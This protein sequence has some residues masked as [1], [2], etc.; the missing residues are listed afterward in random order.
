MFLD[1]K[2]SS[3]KIHKNPRNFFLVLDKLRKKDEDGKGFD[4]KFLFPEHLAPAQVLK[5]SQGHGRERER[6][7]L[8]VYY[9]SPQSFII[10]FFIR[11]LNN[12]GVLY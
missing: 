12:F 11:W 9:T 3:N 1:F 8:A 4:K 6:G 2:K 5:C 10:T 7:T